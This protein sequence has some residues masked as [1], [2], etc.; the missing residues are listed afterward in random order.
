MPR[1]Y[2]SKNYP[3]IGDHLY[4]QQRTGNYYVDMVKRPYIVVSM[5]P[6]VVKV[7]SCKLI[8]NGPRYYDTLPDRIE[9][10]PDG[11]ILELHWAPS[12]GMWQIDK[13]KSGYPEYAHFGEWQYQPYLN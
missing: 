5:T 11:E 8:F 4:L 2:K 10:D 1:V 6:S 12:K 13:Y 7:Q 3:K 9:A